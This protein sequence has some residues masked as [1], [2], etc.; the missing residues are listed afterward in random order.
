MCLRYERELKSCV[1]GACLE[2]CALVDML[3][4]SNYN[5]LPFHI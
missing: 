1:L 2:G 3:L 4:L 5:G